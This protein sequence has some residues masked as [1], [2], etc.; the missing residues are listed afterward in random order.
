M[1]YRNAFL[2]LFVTVVFA[3]PAFA[4]AVSFNGA[5][6]Y[7]T[8]SYG[9]FY[10]ITGGLFPTGTDPNGSRSSGGTFA[11]IW[12]DPY[13]GAGIDT[14]RRD[15]WFEANAGLALT[16]YNGSTSVYDNN[17]IDTGLHGDFYSALAQ[18]TANA[19][20]PGLY[21]T[22]SNSNNF[23]HMYASYFQVLQ[24]TTIT[25]L[26]GYYNLDGYYNGDFDITHPY[27]QMQMSIWSVVGDCQQDNVG[28]LSVNTGNFRGDV[29][30]TDLF[31]GTFSF[32]DTGVNRV[33]SD[34]ST[35]AIGRYTYTL[36]SPFTLKAGEYYFGGAAEIVTPEPATLV[37]F[38]TG[39]AGV[40]AY[41]RRRA[42]KKG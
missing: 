33:F 13:W 14:W 35:D 3:Q 19:S 38:G 32:S 24:D 34:G 5:G 31:A 23:D 15:G 42:A 17:G 9:Y 11:R 18:G 27:I 37:L 40:G 22:Y 41:R 26:S 39:L 7:Q 30:S 36:D 25:S 29:F 12:D 8:D 6:D 21:Q 28:C 20:T 2:S 4:G 10:G 16:M 1:R